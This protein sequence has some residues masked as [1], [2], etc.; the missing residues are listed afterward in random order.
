MPSAAIISANA[1]LARF[2]ELELAGIGISTVAFSK[3]DPLTAD[4]DFAIVDIDTVNNINGI[5]SCP[6][7]T[8]SRGNADANLPWPATIERIREICGAICNVE[9]PAV[10]LSNHQHDGLVCIIDREGCTVALDNRQIKLTQNELILLELLCNA[11]GDT[12]ARET[13]MEHLGAID[14][15]ISDV[16]ICHLRK[17]LEA[18]SGK[19]LIFTVR[20][21]GYRTVLELSE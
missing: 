1:L 6:T 21:Q 18:D 2:F 16:Y 12:V 5:Y 14:G 15:N 20:G 10:R 7:I 4:F 19:R 13:I 11:R 9:I 3:Q 8:V 17:K